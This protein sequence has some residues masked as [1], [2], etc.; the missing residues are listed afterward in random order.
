MAE[1]VPAGIAGIGHWVPDQVIDNEYFTTYLETSDEWIQQ[2]S[3]I[4][5]RH[6][7]EGETATSDLA[8]EA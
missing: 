4:R 1:I 8:L 2:R 6:W 3:G 7:V 5:T